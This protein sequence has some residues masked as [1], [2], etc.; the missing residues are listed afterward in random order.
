MGEFIKVIQSGRNF[1]FECFNLPKS[2]MMSSFCC[3]V[4]RRWFGVPVSKNG[5]LLP[6]VFAQGRHFH[7]GLAGIRPCHGLAV[8]PKIHLGKPFRIARRLGPF[9]PRITVAVQCHTFDAKSGATL[10]E[11]RGAVARTDGSQIWKQRA[12]PRQI[13]QDFRH[14]FIKAHDGNR[15][16]LHALIADD[17]A[18]PIDILSFKEREVRLRCAQVPREFVKCLA[19]RVVLTF[20]NPA[21]CSLP[22]DGFASL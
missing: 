22:R 10:F 17:V 19:L 13:A 2:C 15:A 7:R 8:M 9:R 14:V 4:L 3:D 20:D 18:V 11:L 21:R 6:L 12:A 1:Q 5:F 16:G